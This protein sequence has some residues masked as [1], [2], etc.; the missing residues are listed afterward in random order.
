[1]PKYTFTRRE[2][3]SYGR[4]VHGD[5]TQVGG[6]LTHEFIYDVEPPVEDTDRL[7]ALVHRVAAVVGDLGTVNVAFL[8]DREREAGPGEPGGSEVTP[9]VLSVNSGNNGHYYNV[10]GGRIAEEMSNTTQN[11]DKL[12]ELTQR[13]ANGEAG[14]AEITPAGSQL[15]AN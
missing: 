15:V 5:S 4:V 2:T 1:M 11:V 7:R 10:D 12:V 13:V 3:A 8:P 6:P 14:L 9:V